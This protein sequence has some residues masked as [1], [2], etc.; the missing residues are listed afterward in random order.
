MGQDKCQ[1]ID[2][3]LAWKLGKGP[4]RRSSQNCRG[5]KGDL[6]WREK[7]ED[8]HDGHSRTTEATMG[9]SLPPHVSDISYLPPSLSS[10]CRLSLCQ[11]HLSSSLGGGVSQEKSLTHSKAQYSSQRPRA[12]LEAWRHQTKVLD[13]G[14]WPNDLHRNPPK[15]NYRIFPTDTRSNDSFNL[16][17]HVCRVYTHVHVYMCVDQSRQRDDLSIFQKMSH[18]GPPRKRPWL[19]WNPQQ[20]LLLRSAK[21]KIELEKMIT[22]PQEDTWR[23]GGSTPDISSG[24]LWL[25]RH[26]AGN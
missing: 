5:K 1:I 11:P 22:A 8:P 16:Q 25:A 12:Y 20:G 6:G 24:W 9:L 10:L 7:R 18:L 15:T 13:K 19:P 14:L 21:R 4:D 17:V 26:V 2:L 3:R 23:W